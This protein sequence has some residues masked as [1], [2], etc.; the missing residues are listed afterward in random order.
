MR[1]DDFLRNGE[2]DRSG[3]MILNVLLEME[4]SKGKSTCAHWSGR[5]WWNWWEG[6][7]RSTVDT[8]AVASGM[9]LAKRIN[10]V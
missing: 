7:A 9:Q 6:M 8:V 1:W 10:V 3:G 5:G 2:E 4:L